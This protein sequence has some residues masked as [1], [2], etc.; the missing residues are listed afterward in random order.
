MKKK[1]TVIQTI[2]VT[3]I[4]QGNLNKINKNDSVKTRVPQIPNSC[5]VFSLGKWW[6]N[7]KRLKVL[8]K[9]QFILE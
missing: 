7:K 8:S 2:D 6:P 4:Q 3:Q 1:S 5:S 9:R